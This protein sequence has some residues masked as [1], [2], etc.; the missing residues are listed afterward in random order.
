M[1]PT[2][3]KPVKKKTYNKDNYDIANI[4]SDDSTDDEDAPRKQI[5]EWA[6]GKSTICR[7]WDRLVP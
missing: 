4:A 5:P 6:E 1:T 7:K 3:T 2:R